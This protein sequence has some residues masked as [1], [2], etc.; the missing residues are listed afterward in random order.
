MSESLKEQLAQLSAAERAALLADLTSPTPAAPVETGAAEAPRKRTP[1]DLSQAVQLEF[2]AV[3][4]DHPRLSPSQRAFVGQSCWFK[5]MRGARGP[6]GGDYIHGVFVVGDGDAR[7]KGMLKI[8][9][10]TWPDLQAGRPV[11]AYVRFPGQPDSVLV[12]SLTTIELLRDGD[13]VFT[14]TK[15]SKGSEA[16]AAA[17]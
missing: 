11:A 8:A 17:R 2:R 3:I 9:T 10:K 12:G 13:Q 15:A 7:Q 5:G 4:G 1:L 16:V 6:Q 14:T